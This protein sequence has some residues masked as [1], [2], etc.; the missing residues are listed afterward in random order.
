M[1]EPSKL[2]QYYKMFK[3]CS[4]V[5]FYSKLYKKIH[6]PDAKSVSFLNFLS[7]LSGFDF[8]GYMKVLHKKNDALIFKVGHNF[9]SLW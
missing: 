1:Q 9:V 8:E 5:S 2:I 3:L 7:L 4:D 6:I